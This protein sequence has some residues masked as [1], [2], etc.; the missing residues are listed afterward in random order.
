LSV[1]LFFNKQNL[2]FKKDS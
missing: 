2:N 1:F